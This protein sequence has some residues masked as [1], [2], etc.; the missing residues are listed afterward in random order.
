ML[1]ITGNYKEQLQKHI[2]ADDLPVYYGGNRRDEDGDEKCSKFVNY[3][4][5]IL[6]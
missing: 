3:K 5:I 2:S 1:H 6:L 4:F